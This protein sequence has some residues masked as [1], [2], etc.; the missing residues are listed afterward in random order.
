M[1]PFSL[2]WQGLLV[3][4]VAALTLDTT[5]EGMHHLKSGYIE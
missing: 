1:R 2:L 4:T 5:S 3:H